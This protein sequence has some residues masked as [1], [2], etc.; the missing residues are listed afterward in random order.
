LTPFVDEE[1]KCL[2]A[3]MQKAHLETQEVAKAVF[4]D[5]KSLETRKVEICDLLMPLTLLFSMP[6][7]RLKRPRR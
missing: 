4:S 2:V 6:R 3:Q 1:L 5:L 7:I